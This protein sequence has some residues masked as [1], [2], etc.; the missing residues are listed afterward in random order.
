M[1]PSSFAVAMVFSIRSLACGL[2]RGPRSA[3]SSKPPLTLS[4][5]ARS[6][7]SGSHS[8]VSPI[9]TSALKAMHRCPAAPNAAPAMAFNAWFLSQSGTRAAWFFAPRLAWTR[10]PLAEPRV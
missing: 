9:M 3:P 8:L 6:A 7:S 4:C 10:L 2:I 1:A 5:F